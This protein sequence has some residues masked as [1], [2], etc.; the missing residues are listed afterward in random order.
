MNVLK[1]ITLLLLYCS[2]TVFA[3]SVNMKFNLPEGKTYNCFFSINQNL[4][5]EMLNG[6]KMTV[7][8]GFGF[9]IKALKKN[10]DTT[11]FE[12]TYKRIMMDAAMMSYDSN[13]PEDANSPLA[14]VMGKLLNQSFKMYVD[15]NGEIVKVTGVT[16]IAKSISPTMV[17]QFNDENTL[18]N[19]KSNFNV[20]PNN[21]LKIGDTWNKTHKSAA[22]ADVVATITYILKE[23]NPNNVVV[24][25]V[26]PLKGN[27]NNPAAKGTLEGILKGTATFDRKT[28]V[29]LS[30]KQS[31]NLNMNLLSQDKQVKMV[32]EMNLIL[33]GKIF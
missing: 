27:I 10:N 15:K 14:G 21:A 25:I 13:K 28:G 4:T 3:Q 23:I 1:K 7:N 17:N 30:S 6:Q 29:C 9:D 20:F 19:F 8:M 12:T 22:G 16:E 33:E 11:V 24:D 32:S 18:N 5:S 31:G 26:S 2:S